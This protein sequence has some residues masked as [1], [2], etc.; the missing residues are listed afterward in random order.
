M[1]RATISNVGTLITLFYLLLSTAPLMAGALPA[2]LIDGR[3]LPS[4]APVL[5]PILPAVVNIS[6][7]SR[8][9]VRKSPLLEDPFFRHFF[10][11]PDRPRE[12]VAQSLG[13]GVVIDATHGYVIT[14]HHVVDKA[15]EITVTLQD[16]RILQAHLVGSDSDTDIA[17]IQVPAERL[18]AVPMG[19]SDQLRVGDF[20]AAI[21]NPFGLGQTVTSGIVSALGRSGLGIEG[22]EDFIQTDA[23]INPGNSGGALVNLRGELIGINTA[24]LAPNGGNVGIG[25]A[26]PVNMAHQV[27]TQLTEYGRMRRGRL[28]VHLQDLTPELATA[29]GIPPQGAVVAKVVRGSSA[30]QSGLRVGDVIV[31]INGR[32][33]RSGRD[34]RNTFGVLA[35]G[36]KAELRT[37][38]DGHPVQL[39]VRITEPRSETLAGDQ[40]DPRLR[41]ATFGT[42]SEDSP[43]FGEVEGVMVVKVTPDSSAASVGLQENDL[44]VAVNRQSIRDLDDLRRMGRASGKNMLLKIRRDDSSFLVLLQ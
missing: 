41:G 38:R 26:I 37:L 30:E 23:S 14:N 21:G 20:V 13:S 4:L 6:T 42:I 1:K 8:V 9:R 28:G 27:V 5:E 44:L 18:T 31:A 11:L 35:V 16:G 7:R 36:T 25:F 17:I 34:L 10:D 12:R 15:D 19:D 43:F 22:Y 39:T 2:R 24:I 40:L 3:E 32:S 33:V 29:F